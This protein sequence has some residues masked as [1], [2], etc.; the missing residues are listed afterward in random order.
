MLVLHWRI[1]DNGICHLFEPWCVGGALLLRLFIVL[2]VRGV[3]DDVESE[4]SK[5][6]LGESVGGF[7]THRKHQ[8]GGQIS[9]KGEGAK[10]PGQDFGQNIWMLV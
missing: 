4:G 6:I 3:G 10:C 2:L 9:R 8:R 7:P 5:T 1:N